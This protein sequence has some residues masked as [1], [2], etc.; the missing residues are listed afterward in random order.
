MT[1][2]LR[3]VAEV[4]LGRMRSP[5]TEH[6]PRQLPYLRAANVGDGEL[7]L[8]D[9]KTMHFEP[10]EERRYG[11][12]PGDV[13]VTEASGS[14]GRV[15]QTAQW[16]GRLRRVMFQNTLLRL[17]P[18]SGTNSRFL[19]W[20]SRHAYGSGIY[21]QAA[22]G[23]GIWH[24]GA[25][26]LRG[27]P[28]PNC[29]PSQQVRIASFLDRQIRQLDQLIHSEAVLMDLARERFEAAR[30]RLLTFGDVEFMP[31]QRLTDPRRPIVYGIVQAGAEVPNGIPYIKT[32][33]LGD[34]RPELLSRT[35]V[36][37]DEAYRRARVAP[38]DLVIAMR[39]SIGNLA[40]VPDD[41]HRANLTQ[42]TARIAA[43]QHVD[44]NWLQH[45][46]RTRLVQSQFDTLA[47]GSTFRTLNIWD[48]RRVS[49]PTPTRDM[50]GTGRAVSQLEYQTNELQ[51]RTQ[52]KIDL[53]TER[54]QALITAAVTGQFDVTTARS[55]T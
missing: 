18:R 45:V 17:R 49:I 39:A 54:R 29:D 6:G 28:V 11:L 24:L 15:G 38:G 10:T 43:H 25:E 50:I 48:L 47:V 52:H 51:L 40:V 55:A 7:K 19:Y 2:P 41:L 4:T 3:A 23:L 46:L 42:G 34:L 33:D 36:E 26:R 27:A 21:A 31:L 14:R 37:I 16:T 35:S 20:W 13:L 30:E 12:A 5:G 8:D 53:L 32:G 22:Q 44:K 1:V 9:I